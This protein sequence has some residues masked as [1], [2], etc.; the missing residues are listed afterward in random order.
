MATPIADKLPGGGMVDRAQAEQADR[1]AVTREQWAEVVAV[2]LERLAK[3]RRRLITKQPFLASLVI[4]MSIRVSA[5]VSTMATNG[6]HCL[7]NP[8]YLDRL[9]DEEAAFVVCH[10]ALHRALGHLWRRGGRHPDRW[11]VA[12]D[13][14]INECLASTGF[15]LPRGVLRSER[16]RGWCA[17]EI[18][19]D[20][21]LKGRDIRRD[22]NDPTATHER[23]EDEHKDDMK[24]YEPPKPPEDEDDEDPEDADHEDEDGE[25]TGDEPGEGSSSGQEPRE[26]ADGDGDGPEDGD[27]DGE[28]VEGGERG[29]PAPITGDPGV[30]DYEGVE[31]EPGDGE[32]EGSEGGE[33]YPTSFQENGEDEEGEGGGGSGGGMGPGED[34]EDEERAAWDWE[35][36]EDETTAPM[37]DT[38]DDAARWNEI[39]KEAQEAAEITGSLPPAIQE[40]L[41]R[42]A[43]LVDWRQILRSYI[44]RRAGGKRRTDWTRAAKRTMA[45]G[46]RYFIPKVKRESLRIVALVDVSG[47]T[48]GARE[49][50][51]DEIVGIVDKVHGT[52]DI[53][54]V[55]DHFIG[56]VEDV[57]RANQIP[58]E[59]IKRESGGTAF[60]EAFRWV[61]G[62]KGKVEPDVVVLLTDGWICDMA[63]CGRPRKADVVWCV[64]V[65]GSY[66]MPWGK[67]IRLDPNR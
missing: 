23:W 39:A 5:R 25:G 1:L 54:L 65:P 48:Q 35:S 37:A 28:P 66:E 12:A 19:A 32:D 11:N 33:K 31:G 9:T 30:P 16:Y 22:P 3:I 14:T 62:R 58:V 44:S 56:A 61:E 45:G 49:L 36:K 6:K 21:K 8:D 40:A 2:T 52:L 4:R 34:E 55:S 47:S 59:Q 41:D 18:Y 46:G 29:E 15:K 7:V 10:E 51:L 67:V 60:A 27:E 64:T 24:P 20:L 53:G 63:L 38:A 42:A 57:R 50:F 17:E 13:I 43:A 26:G